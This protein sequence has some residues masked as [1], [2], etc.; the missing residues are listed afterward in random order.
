MKNLSFFIARRYFL[1]KKKKGF[2]NVLSIIAMVGVA[3]GTAA[4]VIV[5]SVFNGLEDLI[6]SLYSSF[7][8]DIKISLK[9]GKFF[10]YDEELKTQ[11]Q[12]IEGLATIVEVVEDN[13][14]VRYNDG[15]SVVRMKGVSPDFEKNAELRNHITE[16]QLKLTEKEQNFAVVGQGIRYDL[17]INSRNNFL[18]LQFYYPKNISPGRSNPSSMYNSGILMPA[19]VFAIEKQY[20]EKYIFV[21]L[22]FARNLIGKDNECTSLEIELE[23]GVSVSEIQNILK[24]KLGDSFDIMNSDEQHASL[25]KAIKIEKLFIY[26]TFS[27]ILAVASFN[28]FF[29]L[30][31]LALDKKRDISILFAMGTPIKTI[32]NIFLKE[33]AIISLSGALTGGLFGFI[34]CLLQQEYGLISMNMASAVQEAYP[35]KMIA[36]D[37]IFTMLSIAIITILASFK[38]A[39]V[40]AKSVE[41]QRL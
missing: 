5:L 14:L 33:G 15:E 17:S 35:V 22:R 28:I 39:Q 10:E 23:D 18:A 38:P 3:I 29:A 24:R 21:P 27:F 6:R 41:I 1:S 37:F 40:A 32:R 16:G 11:I 19:G 25:L 30:T 20:D 2:I 4:L 34:I 7:D 12:N 9:E 36:T 31:M 26:L 8:A 13:V